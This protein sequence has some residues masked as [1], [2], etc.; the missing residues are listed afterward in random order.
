MKKEIY[1]PRKN[2][3]RLT[4]EAECSRDTHEA[5]K[6]RGS[7]AG[8]IGYSSHL[9]NNK[10][11]YLDRCLAQCVVRELSETYKHLI[12]IKLFVRQRIVLGFNYYY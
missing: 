3:K 2:E 4:C 10:I 6:W 1:G 7:W 9:Q 5:E 11:L 12:Y 8:F